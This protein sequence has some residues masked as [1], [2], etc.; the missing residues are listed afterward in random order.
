MGL[1]IHYSGRIADKSKLPQLI[2]EVEEIAIVH[3]W[4]YSIYE[5]EFPNIPIQ[6]VTLNHFLNEGSHDGKLYGIDFTPEGSE[7]VSICFLSNGR[8]SS[9]M[10]LACWGEFKEEKQIVLYNVTVDE[11]GEVEMHSEEV[12][13]TAEDFSRYLYMCSSKTQY[14]GTQAH[15]MIIGVFRYVAKTYLI[16]FKLVDESEFWE[17]GD[18]ELL[19]QNFERYTGLINGFASALSDNKKYNDEDVESYLE[20]IIREFRKRSE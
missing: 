6:G 3:G 8:M 2:E 12:N 10:Q 9:V 11:Q 20:R 5:R 16:D 18:K 14:A 17:T 1:S 13:Q 15:E 4:K 19:L 7:P